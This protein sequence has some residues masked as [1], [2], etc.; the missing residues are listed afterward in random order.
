MTGSRAERIGKLYQ[1]MLGEDPSRSTRKTI[2]MTTIESLSL[3]EC[4]ERML[5]SL[6]SLALILAG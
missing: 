1:A 3:I 4:L 2:S 5:T 6:T